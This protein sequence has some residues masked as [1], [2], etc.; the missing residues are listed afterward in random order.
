M[1]FLGKTPPLVFEASLRTA[2]K[3]CEEDRTR[4]ASSQEDCFSQ[5]LQRTQVFLQDAGQVPPRALQMFG[6][7][8]LAEDSFPK[9]GGESDFQETFIEL[10][11][12]AFI[13]VFSR[14]T[15][16][17]MKRP[18]LDPLC[19]QALLQCMNTARRYSDKS[20][21]ILLIYFFK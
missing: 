19:A 11:F 12:D 17:K 1:S 18:V 14:A 5:H 7:F 20:G 2:K 16:I 21:L 4:F 15:A 3:H 9:V 13:P 8:F 6:C 10:E